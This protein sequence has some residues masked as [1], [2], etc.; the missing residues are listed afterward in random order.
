[1]NTSSVGQLGLTTGFDKWGLLSAPT[2]I[3]NRVDGNYH[4]RDW[5]SRYITHNC[6]EVYDCTLNYLFFPLLIH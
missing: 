3:S 1:V 6:F 5:G 2:I 4:L